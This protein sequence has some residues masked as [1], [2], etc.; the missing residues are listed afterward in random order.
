MDLI[1][2]GQPQVHAHVRIETREVQP[3]GT[4]QGARVSGSSGSSV[5]SPASAY[6]PSTALV[7]LW[8]QEV[9]QD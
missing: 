5:T 1:S 2:R 3:K 6:S 9:H 7:C 4:S 8:V